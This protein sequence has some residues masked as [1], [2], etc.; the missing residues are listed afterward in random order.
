MAVASSL[1]AIQ[2]SPRTPRTPHDTGD[3]DNVEL[4][5]LN[6]AERIQ[7]ARAFLDET[8][9]LSDNEPDIKRNI[10]AKDKR[11]MVLLCVLCKYI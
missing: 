4:S 10:S 8:H 7:S 6:D 9:S 3:E 1:N 5:L 11:A 2:I